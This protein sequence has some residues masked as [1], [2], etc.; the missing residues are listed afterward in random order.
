M[1]KEMCSQR[2]KCIVKEIQ[3]EVTEKIL[4][5]EICASYE[6]LMKRDTEKGLCHFLTALKA[7]KT[8]KE[9]HHCLSPLKVFNTEKR[10]PS[11]SY[12]F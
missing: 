3:W 12:D 6:S 2:K 11:L 1:V 10:T 8:Q 7:F 9:L 4:F 5:R